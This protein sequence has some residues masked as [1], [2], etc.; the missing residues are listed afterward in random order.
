MKEHTHIPVDVIRI[1]ITKQGERAEYMTL[2][3]C[4]P[5]ECE[6]TLRR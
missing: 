5:E 4:T 1:K 3:E 2:S 6:T